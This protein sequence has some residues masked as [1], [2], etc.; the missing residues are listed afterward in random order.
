MFVKIS[1]V[2]IS[3]ISFAWQCICLLKVVSFEFSDCLSTHLS[4]G[5]TLIFLFFFDISILRYVYSKC[6]QSFYYLRTKPFPHLTYF[7][8]RPALRPVMLTGPSISI[9]LYDNDNNKTGLTID[10]LVNSDFLYMNLNK[11][12]TK[13]L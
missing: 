10:Y 12:K 6:L 13:R 8:V 7:W 2:Y 5:S 9:T 4:V 3:I 11:R 1:T